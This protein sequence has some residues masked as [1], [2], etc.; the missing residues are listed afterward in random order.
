ME[1]I[2]DFD[3]GLFRTQG[4]VGV[5]VHIL[6]YIASCQEVDHR[7]ITPAGSAQDRASFCR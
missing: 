7:R 5:G 4:T 3:L 1:G 6:T 2:E